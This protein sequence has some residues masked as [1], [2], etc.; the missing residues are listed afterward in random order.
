MLESQSSRNEAISRALGR[1]RPWTTPEFVSIARQRCQARDQRHCYRAARHDELHRRRSEH[2]KRS[3]EG[4]DA[5]AEELCHV[6]K[7]D[8]FAAPL[9]RIEVGAHGVGRWP[10]EGCR[11]PE[12]AG[13][14]EEDAFVASERHKS[15]D[16]EHQPESEQDA[17]AAFD[18]VRDR[19][20]RRFEKETRPAIGGEQ[21]ATPFIAGA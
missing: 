3:G 19:A 17:N 14:R 20:G 12:H 1:L 15:D 10:E 9:G 13:K 6:Q 16:R 4:A 11:E 21:V 2:E 5:K 8:D 7:A 18:P